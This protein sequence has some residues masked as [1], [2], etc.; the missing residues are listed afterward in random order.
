M[1]DVLVLDVGEEVGSTNVTP[2]PLVWKV[3]RL[4]LFSHIWGLKEGIRELIQNFMDACLRRCQ[5]VV[6]AIFIAK[7]VYL[8][9]SP[10]TLPCK[11]N[12]CTAG[13]RY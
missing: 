2:E 3:D 13:I 7:I 1:W 11:K 4:E 6:L 5:K 12:T 9:S 10:A 8:R